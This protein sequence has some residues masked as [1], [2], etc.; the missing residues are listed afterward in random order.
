[1]PEL[2]EVETMRRGIE[3]IVGRRIDV[4]LEEMPELVAEQDEEGRQ[5]EAQAEAQELGLGPDPVEPVPAQGE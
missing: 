1:M 3:P 5:R 2:P 4:A